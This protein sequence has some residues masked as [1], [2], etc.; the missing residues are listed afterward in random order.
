MWGSNKTIGRYILA[1][2]RGFFAY[3]STL[4]AYLK[5]PIFSLELDYIMHFCGKYVLLT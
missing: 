2:M 1:I 5:L 4:N 3:C